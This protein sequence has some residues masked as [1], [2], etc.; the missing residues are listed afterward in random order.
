M[1]TTA[2]HFPGHGNT[3]TD[4]HLAVARVDDDAQQLQEIELPPFRKASRPESRGYD[5]HV[6]VPTLDR[7]PTA[8]RLPRRYRTEAAQVQGLSKRCLESGVVSEQTL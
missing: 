7:T 6:R 3:A 4:S 1:M 5:A 2:K 8:S